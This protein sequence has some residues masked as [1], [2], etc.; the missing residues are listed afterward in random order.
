MIFILRFLRKYYN[1]DIVRSLLGSPEALNELEKEFN[2]LEEDRRILRQIFPTGDNKV[3]T[4]RHMYNILY[5]CRYILYL[6]MY[7]IL[8]LSLLLQVH[9]PCNLQRMIWN[10]QKIFR[11]NLRQP[12]DLNP[13]EAIKCLLLLCF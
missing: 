2:V 3:Y 4:H 11:I 6:L 8:L 7:H 1:E 12:T 13:I 9:L 10:A 5:I